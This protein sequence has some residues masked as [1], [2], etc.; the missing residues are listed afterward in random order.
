[1]NEENI[2]ETIVD[3][4]NPLCVISL[5]TFGEYAVHDIQ[6]NSAWI[7]NPYENYAVVPD[8]MVEAIMETKGF[9]DITVEDGVVIGFV[10]SEILEIPEPEPEPTMSEL[11]DIL[12][13][14]DG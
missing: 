6:T 9:C 2:T 12:L 5:D 11:M 8:D 1:M 4:K 3:R 10:A 14:G 13:G 7:E